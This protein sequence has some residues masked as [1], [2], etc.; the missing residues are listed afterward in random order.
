MSKKGDKCGVYIIKS[1][2]TGDAYVGGSRMLR[3]RQSNHWS[4]LRRGYGNKRLQEIFDKHG[5]KNL[6]FEVLCECSK[7][8]LQ[9]RE[10]EYI[11]KLK[12]SCNT[13]MNYFGSSVLNG[14]VRQSNYGR[15]ANTKRYAV[16][17]SATERGRYVYG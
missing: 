2:A 17:S 7:E 15:K 9:D 5:E 12:P 13:M 8:E 14:Y 6:V 4:A 16:L 1:L 3:A 11:L 10:N